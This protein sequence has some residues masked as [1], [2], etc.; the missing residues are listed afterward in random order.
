[1]TASAIIKAPPSSVWGILADLDSY[2]MWCP[3]TEAMVGKLALGSTIVEAVRLRPGDKGTRRT[4]VRVTALAPREVVWE[5]TVGGACLLHARRVQTVVPHGAGNAKYTTTDTL[6]GLLAPLVMALYGGAVKAGLEAVAN[7]LKTRAEERAAATTPARHSAAAAA[8]VAA[9]AATT[10][11]A[12][13]A[14][15]EAAPPDD[16]HHLQPPPDGQ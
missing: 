9:S 13:T 1:M 5:S 8:A 15:T 7:A 16:D 2:G 6:S 14:P 12:A 4:V 11:I 10:T 3:F